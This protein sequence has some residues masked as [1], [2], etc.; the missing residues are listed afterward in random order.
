MVVN[1]G[2]KYIYTLEF[3]YNF[4]YSRI[5]DKKFHRKLM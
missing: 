4:T 3:V 5:H 1:V 2:K